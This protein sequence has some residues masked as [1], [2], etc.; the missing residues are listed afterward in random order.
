M[1]DALLTDLDGGVLTLT[2]NDAPR[3]RMTFEY[4]DA[5]EEAI[6][7]AAADRS[8]RAILFTAAG[9]EHFSVGMDLKQLMTGTGDRHTGSSASRSPV[10]PTM[11]DDETASC[12]TR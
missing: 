12:R 3:N 9:D 8:V 10:T 4:M 1:S 2:N 11:T 7:D 5:L 6:N